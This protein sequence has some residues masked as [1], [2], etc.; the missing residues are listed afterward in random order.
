MEGKVTDD[1][2][3]RELCQREDELCEQFATK[4]SIF[5]YWSDQQTPECAILFFLQDG[6]GSCTDTKECKEDRISRNELVKSVDRNRLTGRQCL[7]CCCSPGCAGLAHGRRDGLSIDAAL[8][9]IVTRLVTDPVDLSPCRNPPT[10]PPH[11]L[12]PHF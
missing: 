11:Y 9:A 10:L 8:R 1:E 12:F 5:V 2:E 6:P 4:Q 7:N 3:E